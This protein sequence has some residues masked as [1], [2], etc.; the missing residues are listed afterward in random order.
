MLK[1]AVVLAHFSLF[2]IAIAATTV[3]DTSGPARVVDGDTLYI[4]EHKFRLE[5]MDAPETD[6]ICLT[7]KSEQWECGV[8]ARDELA[9]HIGRHEISCTGTATD[10]YGRTL[11]ICHL[12]AEDLNAWMVRQ[13]FALAYV[14]YSKRYSPLEANAREAKRGLWA[15]AFIAPWDWRHRNRHTVILGSLSVSV[16][17]QKVLLSGSASPNAPSPACAIKGNVN[18]KGERIYHEPGQMHY[19]AVNMKRGSGKRWFCSE[20]EAEAAGWRKAKR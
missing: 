18:R 9:D 8:V 16:G 20:A 1:I 12:G 17:A 11:A 4:G 7:E 10:R 2:N 6:Q 15:G 13:G 5:G 14:R 3:S 19:D